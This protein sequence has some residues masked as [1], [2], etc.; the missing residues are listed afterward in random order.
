MLSTVTGQGKPESSYAPYVRDEQ[1]VFYIYASELAG[2]TQNMLQS[3]K[4][5]ILFIQPEGEA[6]NLFARERI[7]FD[8]LIN[9]VPKQDE[10][11]YK[12]MLI[13]KE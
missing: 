6:K 1:G 10:R 4:V 13:V 7:I 3:H 9:E 11:Y 5:S 2:H 8:C 12:K